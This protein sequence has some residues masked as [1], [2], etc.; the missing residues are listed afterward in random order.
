[1]KGLQYLR[2]INTVIFIIF[3]KIYQSGFHI[4]DIKLDVLFKST[5]KE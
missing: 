4:N 3:Y 2:V 1:M 5:N